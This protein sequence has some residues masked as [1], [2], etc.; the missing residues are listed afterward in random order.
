VWTAPPSSQGYLALAILRVAEKLG[1][2]RDDT[3]P[4]WLRNLGAATGVRGA[5]RP[6]LLHEDARGDELLDEARVDG[7]VDA[8]RR[9]PAS[10]MPINDASG[11]T[12]YL[13]VRDGDG[14]AVSLIQSQA[15]D[16]GAHLVE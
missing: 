11:D 15:S 16:F 14:R 9:W 10:P 2:P 5:D 8:A 13:C 7:W 12:T 1:V 6:A 3:D 4:A